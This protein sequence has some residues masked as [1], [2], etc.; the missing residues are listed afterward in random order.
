MIFLSFSQIIGQETAKHILREAISKEKLPHAYLFTGIQGV[1]K[2]STA[3]ELLMALNC[4]EAPH[5][6]SC[7]ACPTCRQTLSGNSPDFVVMEREPNSQVI[8]VEQI[9]DLNRRLGFAPFGKYRVCVFEEAERMNLEAANSFLKTL[10]EPP[11]G[12]I[13]VLNAVDPAD[14]LPTIVSRCQRV[15]FQPLNNDEIAQWLKVNKKASHEMAEILAAFSGGS[16]G[17]AMDIYEGDFLE[18]REE[19]I[20]KIKKLNQIS[21]DEAF[22]IAVLCADDAKRMGLDSSDK[23]SVGILDMLKVWGLWY[24]D[25][26]LLSTNGPEKLIVN[27]DHRATLKKYAENFNIERLLESIW[28]IDRA[29]R[30]LKQMRNIRLVMEY[31]AI[32]LNRLATSVN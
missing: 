28:I 6:E 1:G 23:G 27:S 19:W 2:T 11:P 14:L 4:P 30:D 13:L 26:L 15:R 21:R 7:G 32:R 17:T 3:K 10:E 8:K 16:L 20:S 24:R 25:V 29:Q 5:G 22:G 18:K 31:T 12:N 9:R